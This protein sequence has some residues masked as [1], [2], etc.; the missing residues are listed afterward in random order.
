[1]TCYR[2]TNKLGTSLRIE[3]AGIVLQARGG[4]DS[5]AVISRDMYDRSRDIHRYR[6]Y[7]D[8]SV[9][10]PESHK[11]P[12]WPLTKILQPIIAK[13][14]SKTHEAKTDDAVQVPSK[15][16][17]IVQTQDRPPVQSEPYIQSSEVLSMISELNRKTDI[18][19]SSL[20]NRTLPNSVHIYNELNNIKEINEP[21]FIPSQI[22]PKVAEVKMNVQTEET[23]TNNIQKSTDALAKLRKKKV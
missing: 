22:M 16:D 13:I 10:V 12:A 21:S 8:I 14:N 1:M 11:A 6:Q 2:I 7:L 23:D 15:T 19:L 3:D 4:Q 9:Y 17:S 20:H 18:I 5:S